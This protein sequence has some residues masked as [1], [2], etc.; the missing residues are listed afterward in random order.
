[1]KKIAIYSALAAAAFL[2]SCSKKSDG[3]GTPQRKCMADKM[4]LTET[5]VSD[6]SS[7]HDLQV[8]FDVKNTSSE[9]YDVGSGSN[10]VYVKLQATTTSGKTYE[11]ETILTVTNLAA[12]ATGSATASVDYGAGNAYKSYKELQVYC[13]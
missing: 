6:L 1:M 8:T 5:K 11:E 7:L 4:Q 9:T 3:P 10:P 13:K 12:G 2:G